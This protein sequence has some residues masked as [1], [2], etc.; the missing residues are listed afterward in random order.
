AGLTLKRDFINQ[1]LRKEIMQQSVIYQEWR[2]EFLQE[3]REEGR[4]EEGQS[5]ILRQLTRCI[6]DV[7]PDLQSQ[8]QALSLDQLEA[9][10]E[11]LLDFSEPTDLVSWLQD[12]R[13]E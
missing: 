7:S 2:E 9:L 3:G 11:A 8:V 6:G 12:N 5:L 1:V 10:G 4:Q 13:T